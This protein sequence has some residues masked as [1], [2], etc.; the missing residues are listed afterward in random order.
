MTC[1]K[2]PEPEP[3]LDVRIHGVPVRPLR[4]GD[5]TFTLLNSSVAAAVNKKNFFIYSIA[6]LVSDKA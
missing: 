5:A 6:I 2:S 3:K 1:I 4:H